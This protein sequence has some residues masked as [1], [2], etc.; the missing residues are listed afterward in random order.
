[1]PEM[2]AIEIAD[3]ERYGN[4]CGFRDAVVDAHTTQAKSLNCS[5]SGNP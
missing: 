3:G 5:G 2:H 1:M 4:V